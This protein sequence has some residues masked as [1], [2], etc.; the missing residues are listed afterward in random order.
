MTPAT[1]V[2]TEFPGRHFIKN[3]LVNLRYD[4]RIDACAADI[5]PWIQQMGYHRG[6]WYIDAWWDRFEQTYLWPYLVPKDARGVYMPPSSVLLQ[7]FQN[8][9][10]NDTIPDGPPGSAFYHVVNAVPNRLLLLY[11]TSHFKY[12]APRFVYRTR[13]APHGA[14]CWAFMLEEVEGNHTRLVSWWQAEAHPKTY[15]LCLKPFI[16]VVD[17]FHQ[18]SILKGIKKRV[19]IPRGL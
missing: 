1:R 16:A 6:G 10:I 3:P 13:F 19:E 5:W 4:I 8:I 9:K 11:A 7:E 17:A 14:F 2:R 15:F 18:K 12:M